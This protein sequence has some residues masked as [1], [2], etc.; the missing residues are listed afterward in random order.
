MK[1]MRSA[2]AVL[3][4]VVVNLQMGTAF[5]GDIHVTRVTH[6]T[7]QGTCIETSTVYEIGFAGQITILSQTTR[8][9]QRSNRER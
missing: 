2:L 1:F 4:V 8:T 5:A 7:D 6:C 9:Y 3:L